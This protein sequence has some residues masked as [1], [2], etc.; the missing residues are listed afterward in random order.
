[1]HLLTVAAWNAKD[2]GEKCVR[3]FET[4]EIR[5]LET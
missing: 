2:C 4:V 1:M 5:K 3:Y